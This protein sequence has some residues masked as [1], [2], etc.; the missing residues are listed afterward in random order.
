MRLQEKIMNGNWS[1]TTDAGRSR[2]SNIADVVCPN[3]SHAT[4]IH[5]I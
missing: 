3:F 2:D 5:T 1:D 4:H